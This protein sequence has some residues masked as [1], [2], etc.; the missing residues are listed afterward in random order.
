MNKTLQYSTNLEWNEIK[1]FKNQESCFISFIFI[2]SLIIQLDSNS[3][4]E[5]I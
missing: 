1:V 5:T 3:T 4:R 2:M